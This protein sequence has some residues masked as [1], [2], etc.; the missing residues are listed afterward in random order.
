MIPRESSRKSNSKVRGSILSNRFRQF[1]LDQCLK[2]VPNYHDAEDLVSEVQLALLTRISQGLVI[3][4]GRKGLAALGMLNL[5]WV[6]LVYFRRKKRFAQVMHLA[7]HSGVCGKASREQPCV[8]EMVSQKEMA[9]I[10]MEQIH[11]MAKSKRDAHMTIMS[12][13]GET[14]RRDSG[15]SF[16]IGF[17]HSKTI[18]LSTLNR[19]RN[20]M[21]YLYR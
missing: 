20:Q 1:L 21:E 3:D 7:A 11:L 17:D 14:T 15:R 13:T 19:V 16:G 6:T 5:K 2:D 4:D 8:S 18:V 12:A 9:S 10:A